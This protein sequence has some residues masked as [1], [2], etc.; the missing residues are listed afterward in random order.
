MR[1][2]IRVR[3]K[4]DK[5]LHDTGKAILIR[6]GKTEYWLARYMCRNLT[7]NKKFGGH[8]SLSVKICED[9]G[10]YF[11]DTMTDEYIET[12]IPIKI[13]EKATHDKSLER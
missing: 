8:V 13:V 7:I 4:F 11:D 5:F 12:H 10:I 2:I 6:I 9:K 1:K 3:I